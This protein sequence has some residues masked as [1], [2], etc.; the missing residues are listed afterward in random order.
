MSLSLLALISCGKKSETSSTA[1]DK[2]GPTKG[3]ANEVSC[4]AEA[5]VTVAPTALA[6]DYDVKINNETRAKVLTDIRL[7]K[8]I[9]AKDF[10]TALSQDSRDSLNYELNM[11]LTKKNN[12]NPTALYQSTA[13]FFISVKDTFKE[14]T[15]YKLRDTDGSLFSFSISDQKTSSIVLLNSKCGRHQAT[16]L[17][18]IKIVPEILLAT[19]IQEIYECRT[20]TKSLILMELRDIVYL[21]A[22]SSVYRLPLKDLKKKANKRNLT[23]D[24]ETRDVQFKIEIKKKKN[25]ALVEWQGKKSEIELI[26]P[27]YAIDGKGACNALKHSLED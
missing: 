14:Y 25:M 7:V 1:T 5:S 8:N 22:G 26:A 9:E 16:D 2:A 17:S 15:D 3:I 13:H 4:S 21:N 20:L 10:W 19:E 12:V 27:E 18:L 23:L 11:I 6:A 24:Y